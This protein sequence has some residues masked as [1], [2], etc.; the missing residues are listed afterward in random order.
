MQDRGIGLKRVQ[1]LKHRWQLCV[2][3]LD[4]LKSLLGDI[5]I[6]SGDGRHALTKETHPIV[7]QDGNVLHGS[8]PQPSTHIRAGNDGVNAR[9]LPRCR[10]VDP[11]D[12]GMGIGTVAATCPTECR[13]GRY[14]PDNEPG[15]SPCQCHPPVASVAQ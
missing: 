13:V 4:Q 12:A 1:R 3:N 8:A 11:D 9:H 7:G 15:P 14:Q 10:G 5:L 2:F 6:L